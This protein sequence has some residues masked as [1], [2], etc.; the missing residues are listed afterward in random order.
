MG[1]RLKA[2]QFLLDPLATFPKM[3]IVFV[4]GQLTLGG[5]ETYICR[6]TKA[7]CAANHD[8]QVWIV[9]PAFDAKLLEQL[10][11]ICEVRFLSDNILKFPLIL[12]APPLPVG[13]DLVF[14]TGRLA[15]I[16]AAAACT[17]S[18]QNVR[19]VAGVFS[20]WEYAQG[21]TG[22]K[23]ALAHEIL[24]QIGPQNMVFCTEGCRSDHADILGDVFRNSIVSPLLIDLPH[25]PPQKPKPIGAALSM[26]TVG[27]FV[28]FKT[29]NFQMPLILA[30]LRNKGLEVRWTLYGAGSEQARIEAAMT[31]AGVADLVDLP[32]PIPYSQL[33]H[34]LSSADIYI[35]AGTTLIEAS[36]LGIPAIIALD[37]NPE[38]TSPGF[39]Y[40]REGA[41]T[42]DR[43]P[44]DQLVLIEDL[45]SDFAKMSPIDKGAAQQNSIRKAN[46]YS[47]IAA[48][49][50]FSAIYD[51]AI[52]GRILLPRH[53]KLRYSVGALIE[54]FRYS[55]GQGAQVVR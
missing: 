46:R 42:S 33:Q 25:I 52:P 47:T 26:V 53:S 21:K 24:E 19:L 14:T 22:Y 29:S 45:I 11:Q 3:K 20:Q 15:L 4:V 34:A 49:D 48:S 38:P 12:N 7:L 9:K 31:E 2:Y 23:S 35:G 32:G 40:Q 28:P 13:T 39:F 43:S 36:A 5:V 41:Y 55:I 10:E 17:R 54:G 8:V 16:F 37:D 18:G 30:H 27:N 1:S 44:L 6:M 50:E 51:V